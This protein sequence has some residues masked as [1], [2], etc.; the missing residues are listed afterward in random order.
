MTSWASWYKKSWFKYRRALRNSTPGPMQDFYQAALPAP[1]T[2]VHDV[3]FVALDF[4]TT[5]LNPEADHIISFGLV[6]VRQL[7]IVLDSA[8][9]G[10]VFTPRDMPEDSAVIHHITDD[11]VAN[12]MS[13]P[14][15]MPLLLKQLRGKVLL[16]HHAQLELGFLNKICHNLYQQ[17]FHL[18]VVDTEVLARRRLQRRGVSIKSGALRLFNLRTHYHLPE[19]T[20]HQALSDAIATAE[21]F[22][23][24]AAESCPKQN[25]KLK[26]LVTG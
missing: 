18:P 4:E 17:G 12:G 16:V 25:C 2:R 19:Y 21:L 7:A 24:Q 6:H 20:A 13:I 22:L 5:G 14:E 26:Q 3:E 9:H 10:I 11:T 23:A 15:L 1:G 8:W